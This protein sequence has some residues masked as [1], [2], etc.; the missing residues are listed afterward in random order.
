MI[1]FFR[2]KSNFNCEIGVQVNN[3]LL[4]SNSA[5]KNGNGSREHSAL[6]ID[7]MMIT[8]GII[9]SVSRNKVFGLAET[10][11]HGIQSEIYQDF[12]GMQEDKNENDNIISTNYFDETSK[13]L[14]GHSAT[15]LTQV[16][17]F[18][19]KLNKQCTLMI[20]TYLKLTYGLNN[21]IHMHTHTLM[22]SLII[23]VYLYTFSINFT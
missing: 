17:H 1:R 21:H 18:T 13:K 2:Y 16:F 5:I 8:N 11:S 15:G 19:Y 6:L 22:H 20:H 12:Y 7:E 3:L 4:A 10:A 14:K 23:L 9:Y